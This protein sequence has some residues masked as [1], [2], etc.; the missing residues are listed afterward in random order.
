M[1]QNDSH[2]HLPDTETRILRAAEQE[3]LDK[4]FAAART[5]S[6]AEAAGV[7]HAMFHYYFRTKEKLFDRIVSD[8]IG[9]VKEV[10]M[11]SVL[12][13]NDSLYD[14][15]KS[16]IAG[17]LD[18][19]AENP[20]LPRFILG[21]MYSGSDRAK[22]IIGLINGNSPLLLRNLQ[23]MIDEAAEKGLCRQVDAKTLILDIASLNIF[24]F[25]AAPVVNAA[26]DNCMVNMTE[27]VEERKR[28]NFDTIMRKLKP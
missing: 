12:T 9:V 8:K 1:S 22:R 15:I 17:H 16:V 5:T 19:L 26:L 14:L 13:D 21:E 10:I 4:G 24:S 6:I 7:T 18:F 3:F 23:F 25:V 2:Q 27:F 11:K 20:Q 28:N